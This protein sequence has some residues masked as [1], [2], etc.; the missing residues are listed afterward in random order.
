MDRSRKQAHVRMKPVTDFAFCARIMHGNQ[1]LMKRCLRLKKQLGR[2][3]NTEARTFIETQLHLSIQ[4][5]MQRRQKKR[6]NEHRRFMQATK[7][8]IT[9]VAPNSLKDYYSRLRF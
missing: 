6:E 9:N 8:R 5:I 1:D 7:A 4:S 2:V 3:S